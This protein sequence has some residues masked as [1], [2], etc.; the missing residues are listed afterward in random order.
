M[1]SMSTIYVTDYLQPTL[2]QHYVLDV[3]GNK[4]PADSQPAT[5][6]KAATDPKKAKESKWSYV[7][8]FTVLISIAQVAV[9]IYSVVKG[10]FAPLSQNI[11]IGPPLWTLVDLGAKDAFLMRFDHQYYRFITPIFVHAGILHIV[12]NLIAQVRLGIM[13]E[14]SWG[15]IKFLVIYFVAGL[16][17][18][19]MSCLLE[20]STI[21]V[22]ASGAILGIVGAYFA[23]IVL[24]WD[25]LDPKTKKLQ[26]IQAIFVVVALG[27]LSLA[28]YVDWA[29]HLGGFIVGVLLGFALLP[30]E[31]HTLAVRRARGLFVLGVVIFFV[32]GLW[33]FYSKENPPY[34]EVS[35][36]N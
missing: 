33:Y 17:S 4:V 6:A 12:L 28:P 9:F 24:L 15:R 26:V 14:K 5:Q 13:M 36:G 22:G 30:D 19:L 11:N 35:S 1:S 25:V 21:S 10:G 18:T 34:L 29:M 20:P 8:T 32:V 2:M 31:R 23:H 3:D 16:A 7:L 27:L